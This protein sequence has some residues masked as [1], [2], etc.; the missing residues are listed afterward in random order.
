MPARITTVV[1]SDG[2]R[3]YLI[4]IILAAWASGSSGGGLSGVGLRIGAGIGKSVMVHLIFGHR[5]APT[6]AWQFKTKNPGR[7]I[8]RAGLFLF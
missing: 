7:C 5:S 3:P 1:A 2:L 6:L 4:A 8:Q